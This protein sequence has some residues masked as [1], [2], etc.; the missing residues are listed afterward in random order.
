MQYTYFQV[1]RFGYH[2]HLFIGADIAGFLTSVVAIIISKKSA[3][4]KYTFGF[5]R[6]QT[7]GALASVA[8]VWLMTAY[9]VIE[10][11][12]R[13][14]NPEPINGKL[15]FFTALFGVVINIM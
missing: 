7:L 8:F 12:E 15:M 10:A 14:K 11:I 3:N 2:S 9:L 4:L 13:I 5:Q 6:A 1:I